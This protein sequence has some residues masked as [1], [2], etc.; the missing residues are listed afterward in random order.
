MFEDFGRSRTESYLCDV[1]PV[2]VEINEI[3][4]SLEKGAKPEKHASG[5]MCFPSLR[6]TV[7]KMPYGVTLIISPYNF[8]VLLSPMV[9]IRTTP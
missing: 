1:G 9:R 2:I 3:L 5:L 7:Y 4:R 8:P 6:T